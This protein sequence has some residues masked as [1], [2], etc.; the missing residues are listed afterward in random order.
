MKSASDVHLQ[1]VATATL[2]LRD[3]F[4]ILG[5][6]NTLQPL[7]PLSLSEALS[8]DLKRSDLDEVLEAL[9]REGLVRTLPTGECVVTAA[10]RA[11][12]GSGALAK[13]RDVGR[14]LHLFRTSKGGRE[15]D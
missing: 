7:H 1:S 11:V 5:L 15:G 13:E 8:R 12:L 14:L 4:L 9:T 3:K 10:G 2:L 6:L